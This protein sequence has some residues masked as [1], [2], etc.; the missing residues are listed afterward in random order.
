MLLKSLSLV[1]KQSETI[2]SLIPMDFSINRHADISPYVI[3]P[4]IQ[5]ITIF[6]CTIV[7]GRLT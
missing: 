4:T 6:G 1:N 3:P 5:I 2:A 7:R